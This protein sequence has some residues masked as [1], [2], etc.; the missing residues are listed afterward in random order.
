MSAG[1]CAAR[2]AVLAAAFN[3]GW[4]IVQLPLYTLYETG[5]PG[6][7]AFA[8]AHCTAGDVLIASACHAVAAIA[9]RQSCWQHYRPVPGLVIYVAATLAYTVFSEWLNVSVRGSWEYAPA[10]PTVAGIGVAPLLQWIVLPP[11]MLFL[12]RRRIDSSQ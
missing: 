3:L 11:A 7:I 12:H 10:M 2:W 6:S 1:R 9:T 5:T 4:E 8:I